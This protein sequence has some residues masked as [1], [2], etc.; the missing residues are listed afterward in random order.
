[1]V[2]IPT[3]TVIILTTMSS[4]VASTTITHYIPP[5][6]GVSHRITADQ[7]DS[8]IRDP[9]TGGGWGFSKLIITPSSFFFFRKVSRRSREHRSFAFTLLLMNLD[10]TLYHLQLLMISKYCLVVCISDKAVRS[11]YDSMLVDCCQHDAHVLEI[12]D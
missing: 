10:S 8:F 3:N 11:I 5:W 12:Q 9:A 7:S 4:E 1:M 2:D 6:S